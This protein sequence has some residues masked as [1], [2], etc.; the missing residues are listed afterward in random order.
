MASTDTASPTYVLLGLFFNAYYVPHA[1]LS[2][3]RW[4]AVLAT[5]LAA[6]FFP[7]WGIVT[8]GIGFYALGPFV[9]SCLWSTALLL[10][11]KDWAAPI[12]GCGAGAGANVGMWALI[13]GGAEG[14]WTL[15][16]APAAIWHLAMPIGCELLARRRLDRLTPPVPP[17]IAD[18]T[19]VARAGSAAPGSQESPS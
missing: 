10:T 15:T 19:D 12:V 7:I 17:P 4:P 18:T 14:A 6:T 16:V 1:I 13:V 2:R 5:A 3:A 9:T 11:W 8:S